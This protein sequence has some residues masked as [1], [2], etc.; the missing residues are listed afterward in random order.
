MKNS[1]FL[2]QSCSISNEENKEFVWYNVR[3]Y[4]IYFEVKEEM[5]HLPNCPMKIAGV[6]GGGSK[7]T[8]ILFNLIPTI[9]FEYPSEYLQFITGLSDGLPKIQALRLK[10]KE[11]VSSY[12]HYD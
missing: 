7:E 8:R 5:D 2:S 3:G 9:G 4:N 1:P 10:R 6:T 12:K 11:I